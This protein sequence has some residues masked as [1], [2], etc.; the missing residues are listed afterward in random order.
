MIMM[1]EGMEKTKAKERGITDRRK[2]GWM[3]IIS[4]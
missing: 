2:I 1:T 3:Q 4:D